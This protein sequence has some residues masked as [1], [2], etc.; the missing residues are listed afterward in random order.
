MLAIAKVESNWNE[1]AVG[2]LGE[3]G[4]LQ[5]RPELFPVTSRTTLAEH[6][7][8]AGSYIEKLAMLCAP[9]GENWIAC[10]NMGPVKAKQVIKNNKLARYTQK[11]KEALIEINRHSGPAL[12]DYR[13]VRLVQNVVQARRSQES[14]RDT[15]GRF[16]LFPESY[17]CRYQAAPRREETHYYA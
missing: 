3:L 9:L 10:Y 12:P 13:K 16:P 2:S 17:L 14:R 1:R 11:V 15:Q 4:P 7:R 8:L 5:M 6:Y